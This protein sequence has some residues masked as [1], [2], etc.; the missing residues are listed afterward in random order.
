MPEGRKARRYLGLVQGMNAPS[1]R[2][3]VMLSGLL[4]AV[5]IASSLSV[6]EKIWWPETFRVAY[7][8]LGVS[9]LAELLPLRR[10]YRIL[11]QLAS[12]GVI[13]YAA[14]PIEWTPYD[15]ILMDDRLSYLADN[16]AALHPFLEIALAV[17]MIYILFSAWTRIRIRIVGF[18]SVCLLV[19]AVTDSFTPI[20]LW[21][22][23]AVVIFAGLVWL[24]AEHFARFQRDHPASWTRLKSYP[25]QLL[26]PI[27]LVL[28]LVMATGLFV[29]EIPPII[30]DP[31]T[32]WKEAQGE[33]VQSFVGDKGIAPANSSKQSSKSGYSREDGKLGGGFNY[34]YSPVMTVKSDRK[35][36]WRGE[37]KSY[38][39]GKGWEDS[40]LEKNE[41]LMPLAVGSELSLA[42]DRSA[43][44]TVEISQE[45]KMARKDMFPVLFGASAIK[46]LKS[47][48]DSG[49]ISGSG[50]WGP[51][52]ME[53]RYENGQKTYPKTYSIVS[54]Q[55][56]VDEGVKNAKAFMD[57]SADQ[58]MYT[59][60]PTDIPSR[61]AQ[62]GRDLTAAETTDFGK[63]AAIETYLKVNYPYTNEPDTSKKVSADFVDSFLFEIQEGYCD[64]YSSAMVVLA[65]SVDLPARWVKGYASGSNRVPTPGG[66]RG[67]PEEWMESDTYTVRNSDAHSWVEI[68]FQGYG[69]IP[70]EPTAGFAYPYP[71]AAD[72]AA[73]AATPTPAPSAAPATDTE[74]AETSGF[75][76]PSYVYV[77]GGIFLAAAAAAAAFVNRHFLADSWR[78]LRIRSLS[79]EERISWDTGRMIRS[80]RRGG[81]VKEDHETLREAVLRWSKQR[82]Y[83]QQELQAILADFEK[84]K[85]SG[86]PV[87][88]GD[89][90]AFAGKVKGVLGRFGK[91]G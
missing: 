40:E 48:N 11:L 52:S 3:F 18:T 73:A 57:N 63:A 69:W 23:T 56:L 83:L 29:P 62:L 53:L 34:D 27:V 46:S 86:Q 4:T 91:P 24:I 64:Y 2:W 50:G 84:V 41:Q 71:A 58:Q 43:A 25:A 39:T 79:A 10:I 74:A 85:Y 89:A 32:V 33:Q 5:M 70:F 20:Y 35:S 87:S 42:W 21:D 37:T 49:S 6:L 67:G 7:L 1:A 76:V 38:Y 22:N 61:V 28:S 47:V 14:A 68:Y 44:E 51:S 19:L 30:K 75:N 59:Q 16:A 55:T 26:L 36:Y 78:R 88:Y 72:D 80:A 60:L 82:K 8:V 77:I 81:L 13:L 65:R 17:W 54:E 45:F 66:M 31:Y 90:E 15:P 12:I 9:A